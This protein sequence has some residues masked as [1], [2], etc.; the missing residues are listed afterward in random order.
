MNSKMW[1]LDRENRLFEQKSEVA[2]MTNVKPKNGNN[3]LK[4]SYRMNRESAQSKTFDTMD[5]I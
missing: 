4:H 2:S 3:I 5:V 1:A